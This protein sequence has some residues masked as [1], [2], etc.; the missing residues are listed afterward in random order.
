[1]DIPLHTRLSLLFGFGERLVFIADNATRTTFDSKTSFAALSLHG[2][3]AVDAH[4]A[5]RARRRRRN[6]ADNRVAVHAL[7]ID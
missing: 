7:S 5:G 2:A 1:M 6:G 3:M 4:R